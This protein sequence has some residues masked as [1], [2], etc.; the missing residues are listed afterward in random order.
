MKRACLVMPSAL[1]C[2]P[3]EE[4]SGVS[5]DPDVLGKQEALIPPWEGINNDPNY[6]MIDSLRVPAEP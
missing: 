2:S 3:E 5:Q 6:D 4:Q 1:A